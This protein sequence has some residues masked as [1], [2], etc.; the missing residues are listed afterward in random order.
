MLG[1]PDRERALQWVD[2][3]DICPWIVD[4]VEHDRRGVFNAVGPESR[5][6]GDR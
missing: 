4:L 6:S 2:V 5:T 1:P 3:R